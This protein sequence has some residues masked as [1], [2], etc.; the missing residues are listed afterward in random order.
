MSEN[1][2]NP[3]DEVPATV[4]AFHK[5]GYRVTFATTAAKVEGVV[6]WLQRRSFA[7]ER[8]ARYAPDGSPICSKHGVPMRKREKQ[9]DVWYS[10]NMGTAEQPVYCKGCAGK[11]SPGWEMG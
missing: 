1:G 10:H 2:K 5:T 9:G 8:S 11:D 6:A 3:L 7:A 4:E